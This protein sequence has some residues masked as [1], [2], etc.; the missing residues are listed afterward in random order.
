[1]KYCIKIMTKNHSIM[2]FFT[3]YYS[4]QGDKYIKSTNDVNNEKIKWFKNLITLKKKIE[5]LFINNLKINSDS[6]YIMDEKFTVV[7]SYNGNMWN[8]FIGELK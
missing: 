3:G 5:K 7:C 4:H 8:N 1:M 2:G 6:V